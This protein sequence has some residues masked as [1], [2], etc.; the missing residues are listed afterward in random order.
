MSVTQILGACEVD[1]PQTADNPFA[2][3]RLYMA[4][5]LADDEGLRIAYEANVAMLLH[6]H[7]NEADFT[8]HATRNDAARQIL[9]LIFYSS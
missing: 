9:Q 8:D 6:D 5:A 3:A 7:F 2:A 4:Q 1:P